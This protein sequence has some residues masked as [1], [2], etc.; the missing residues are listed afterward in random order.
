MAGDIERQMDNCKE[1][2]KKL[3]FPSYKVSEQWI[4]TKQC[5]LPVTR[6]LISQK[7]EKK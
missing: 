7:R 3:V 4:V 2:K 6:E 1:S 5:T